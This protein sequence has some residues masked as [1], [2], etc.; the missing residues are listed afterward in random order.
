MDK[1]EKVRQSLDQVDKD[2]HIE[3]MEQHRNLDT[4]FPTTLDTGKPSAKYLQMT[5][6]LLEEQPCYRQWWESNNSCLLLLSGTTVREGQKRACGYSWLSPAASD[7]AERLRRNEELVAFFNCHRTYEVQSDEEPQ[8]THVMAALLYQIL[9]SQAQIL[10]ENFEHRLQNLQV[11]AWPKQK[12][13]D[14]LEVMLAPVIDTL[15]SITHK[16]W[17]YLIIDRADRCK[18]GDKIRLVLLLEWLHKVVK[19]EGCRVK[20][21]VVWDSKRSDMDDQDWEDFEQS[22]AGRVYS[23]L[24]WY[25]DRKQLFDKSPLRTPL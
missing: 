14:T 25:Q 7:L 12:P 13:K 5:L 24:G 16:G 10:R 9:K 1:L 4:V 11:S 22:A 8:V 15:R 3:L 6:P 17:T 19:H 2:L 21:F 20:V 23:K 18:N